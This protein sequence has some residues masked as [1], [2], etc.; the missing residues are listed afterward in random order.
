V[1]TESGSSFSIAAQR[2]DLVSTLKKRIQAA[3]NVPASQQI[4]VFNGLALDDDKEFQAYAIPDTFAV[5]LV[6]RTQ[7]PVIH[8][9]QCE[10]PPVDLEVDLNWKISDLKERIQAKLECDVNP[11]LLVRAHKT[12]MWAQIRYPE[13]DEI[14]SAVGIWQHSNLMVSLPSSI[15][16]SFGVY[17]KCMTGEC[18]PFFAA[19]SM[20]VDRFKWFVY[21]FLDTP[22]DQQRLIYAGKQLED[23][24]TF[25]DYAV[26]SNA[27]LHQVLRLRG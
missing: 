22:V 13:D 11:I 20:R 15:P 7:H 8:L 10:A 16:D 23:E 14:L 24:K 17:L 2:T 3:V 21:N 25:Q 4:L 26:P 9:R 19:P 5:S 27:T 18:V 1:E 6:M 12:G